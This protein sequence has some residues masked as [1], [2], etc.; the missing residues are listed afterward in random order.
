LPGT[1]QALLAPFTLSTKEQIILYLNEKYLAEP[2][3][4]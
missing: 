3:T 1:I 4:R 2:P